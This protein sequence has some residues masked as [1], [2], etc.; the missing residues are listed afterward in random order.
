[1]NKDRRG[2]MICR[3]VPGAQWTGCWY[4][5]SVV[6]LDERPI[7]DEYDIN[8]ENDRFN[9]EEAEKDALADNM[10]RYEDALD[11][12]KVKKMKDWKDRGEQEP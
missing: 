2:A 6:W 8:M 4:D 11:R 12:K 9:M 1:M 10:K 5:D 3:L 7:P